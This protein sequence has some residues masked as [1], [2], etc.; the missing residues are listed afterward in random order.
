MKKNNKKFTNKYTYQQL[1]SLTNTYLE[2]TLKLVYENSN[3]YFRK[4]TEK[5]CITVI[6]IFFYNN[7]VRGV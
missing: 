3:A 4:L 2:I 5:Y 6:V 7:D 1:K